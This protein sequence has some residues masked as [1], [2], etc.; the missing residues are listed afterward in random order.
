[1]A[2]SSAW[3]Q[4]IIVAIVLASTAACAAYRIKSAADLPEARLASIEMQRRGDSSALNVLRNF[5]VFLSLGL[6]PGYGGYRLD[7]Q[8]LDDEDIRFAITYEVG[9]GAHVARYEL[10][11]GLFWQAYLS[12]IYMSSCSDEFKF[13]VQE[14]RRYVLAAN[15]DG[16]PV[17]VVLR[18]K[19]TEVVV[20]RSA[21]FSRRG[22]SDAP[23]KD[24]Q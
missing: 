2:R 23:A 21:C 19:Q 22:V 16:D 17:E 20:A 8:K 15:V 3:G 4:R 1:M 7:L 6:L 13:E 11:Y 18:D 10:R 9:A 12:P 24:P 14:G 5:H